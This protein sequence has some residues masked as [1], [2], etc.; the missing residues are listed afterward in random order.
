MHSKA[1][2]TSLI[3]KTLGCPLQR[4]WNRFS[5]EAYFITASNLI[6]AEHCQNQKQKLLK[7]PKRTITC[8]ASYVARNIDKR[9]NKTLNNA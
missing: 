5:F 3:A 9:K 8:N 6:L 1:D 4:V 2:G 7:Q